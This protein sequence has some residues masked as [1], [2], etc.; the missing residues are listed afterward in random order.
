MIVLKV[1]KF[2]ETVS[3]EIGLKVNKFE[4]VDNETPAILEILSEI[5]QHPGDD[6]SIINEQWD[7]K[8][9]KLCVRGNF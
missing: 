1:N 2:G 8:S 4:A 9:P 3:G 7:G 5:K 6:I